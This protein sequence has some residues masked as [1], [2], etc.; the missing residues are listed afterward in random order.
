MKKIVIIG[1]PG[2]GKSTLAR[3]LGKLLDIKVYHLDRLFWDPGW[4]GKTRETRIDILQHL[5][6]DRQWI[7]EGTYL[8]SSE[9]RLQAAD[10]IVFI[11]TP[12]YR[13]LWRIIKRH[14]EFRGQSRRDIP[15]GCADK[16]TFLRMLKVLA[17]PF[18]DKRRI[19]QKLESYEA[20]EIF[21]LHSPKEANDF[22][23]VHGLNIYNK[24]AIFALR[25]SK[26]VTKPL[27]PQT[28]N[29]YKKQKAP[30]KQPVKLVRFL[31]A[32]RS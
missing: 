24:Q 3:Q 23:S 29:H 26:K 1:S 13:C 4:E 22:L 7:I 16:L 28:L 11:D 15:Q 6:G 30:V 18:H 20:K 9:P 8:K 2:A 31:S 17:F 21:T 12:S 32:S 19:K 27:F 25:D 5:S 10:T 14:Y